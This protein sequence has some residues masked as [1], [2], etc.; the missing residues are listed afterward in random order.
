LATG[1]AISVQKEAPDALWTAASLPNGD[2]VA[3]G[4]TE[5]L[6]VFHLDGID[7]DSRR[8]IFSREAR[9]TP[10]SP[11]AYTKRLVRDP[12]SGVTAFGRSDGEIWIER[13]GELALLTSLGC[14]VR[15]L[16]ASKN[17]DEIFAATEDGR[18]LRIEAPSGQILAQF[19]TGGEPFP[20]AVWALA[21]NPVRKLV[22]AAEFGKSLHILDAA[23][24]TVQ[25][26]I[27]CDR[28]KRIRWTGDNS[29]L[30]GSS[31]AI[32]RYVLGEKEPVP[33]VTGMQNTIED[34]IWDNR[35]QYL[36][37]VCYQS[38]I[39]LFDFTTGDRLDHVR[40]Q[41]DYPL[42]LAWL[43]ST[44]SSEA[45]PWNF[46]T[47]GRSG[48]LHMYRVHNERIVALGP[49]ALATSQ[50]LQVASSSAECQLA[51]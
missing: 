40:D 20:R 11:T 45:Y 46:V 51:I 48:T 27:E 1:T 3:A 18:I 28:V 47:W 32:H 15:D 23:T 22:A 49:V 7:R 34:F 16:T 2:I 17:G 41:V 43:D 42:G 14:A 6:S 36:L 26:T 19:Q 12:M 37:A 10:M 29:F 13:G 30:F 25:T 24:L 4:E 5:M 38:T 44:I 35:R 8:Q 21:Y 50:G 39:G 33:L 31:D 9:P